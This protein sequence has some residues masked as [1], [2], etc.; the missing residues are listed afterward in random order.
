MGHP[1][2][3]PS[4][5]KLQLSNYC[6]ESNKSLPVCIINLDSTPL[7]KEIVKQEPQPPQ[8][9]TG[10][11]KSQPQTFLQS[12]AEGNS[13]SEIVQFRYFFAYSKAF[14]K[15]YSYRI[16]LFIVIV[17]AT[18]SVYARVFTPF[19]RG[20]IYGRYQRLTLCSMTSARVSPSY[21]GFSSAFQE[22]YLELIY[23]TRNFKS[24]YLSSLA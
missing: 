11:V 18:E 17:E 22:Y 13:S 3:Q 14:W 6:G 15:S 1:P 24:S 16:Y 19:I 10:G 20:L 4:A 9:L 21:L 8:S 2:A 23:S 12:H 5:I 7:M